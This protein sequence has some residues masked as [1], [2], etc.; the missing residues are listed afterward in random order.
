MMTVAGRSESLGRWGAPPAVQALALALEPQPSRSADERAA[1][2]WLALADWASRRTHGA[3]APLPEVA[4]LLELE[5]RLPPAFG[6]LRS[7]SA[8]AAAEEPAAIRV[9][10]T[11]EAT[12]PLIRARASFAAAAKLADDRSRWA[13]GAPQMTIDSPLP[14]LLPPDGKLWRGRLSKH[15]DLLL[16]LAAGLAT[17]ETIEIAAEGMDRPDGSGFR[18]YEYFLHH[19]DEGPGLLTLKDDSGWIELRGSATSLVLRI[20]KRVTVLLPEDLEQKY[21]AALP[22]ALSTLLWLWAEGFLKQVALPEPAPPPSPNV[23]RPGDVQPEIKRVQ[24]QP[25]GQGGRIAHIAVLGGGPAGLACAWLLSNPGG[26]LWRGPGDLSLKVTLIEKRDRLGGKAASSRRTAPGDER[27]EEHGLHVLMGCYRNL[28]RM[29]AQVGASL[30]LVP[31]PGTRIPVMPPDSAADG[32]TVELGPWPEADPPEPMAEWFGKLPDATPELSFLRLDFDLARLWTRP[33]DERWTD[34]PPLQRT[35]YELGHARQQPRPLLRLTARLWAHVAG[36]LAR[37]LPD[38]LD[39]SAVQHLGMHLLFERLARTELVAQSRMS[40][41][42]A[43]AQPQAPDFTA[44]DQ[45]VPLA[46][47]L[48]T[49]ARVALPCDS[50]HADVRLAG[51]AIELATTVAIGLA[52]AGLFPNWAIGRID[53]PL[54][55]DYTLWARAVQSLDTTALDTWLLAEGAAPGYPARSRLLDAVTAGLFTTPAGIAAGTFVHGLIRL[56]FTYR[57]TPYL[58]LKGGTGEAVIKPIADSMNGKA[59]LQP[60]RVLTGLAFAADGSVTGVT[61]TNVEGHD[62]QTLQVDAAVLAIP[63]FGGALDGL[64][65]PQDL[66]HALQPIGHVATLSIQHWTDQPARFPGVILSGLGAPMRCVATMDHLQGQEGANIPNAPVYYCG[67]V[68]DTRAELWDTQEHQLALDWL[69]AHAGDFQAGASVPLPTV[70]VNRL[71]SDRYVS[72]NPAT[73]Q[74][75]RLVFQTGVPNL[76]LA[77]DW[78]RNAFSCGAIEGAVSSGLE[79]ARDLLWQLGCT[80]D[81]P[82]TGPMFDKDSV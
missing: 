53:D 13:I 39:S 19:S 68:D 3:L 77:G 14:P 12:T 61:T 5:A 10:R 43:A 47:L 33:L 4:Q 69:A 74:A 34:V 15:T 49:L 67:E 70:K 29:L 35:L 31:R 80:V 37:G 58:M 75:R 11:Y 57:D 22:L 54:G 64:G 42:Q 81:F 72:A 76:W 38:T 73:Q 32:V 50:P 55:D 56:F 20:H 8:T 21:G 28:R 7:S 40:A 26:A 44:P 25:D 46:S 30:M 36:V 52:N 6:A 66:T 71:G 18:R 60:L 65:L 41:L 16:P 82:I 24:P 27:I 2:I 17:H 59:T 62:P 1:G 45:L 51:D 63:P 79:A 78:T 9:A 48:R 23:T